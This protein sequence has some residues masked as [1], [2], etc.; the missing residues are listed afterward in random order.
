MKR[1]KASITGAMPASAVALSF[2]ASR[3]YAQGPSGSSGQ[4]GQVKCIGGN[5]CKGMS[6]C[7][8][9]SNAGP[10]RNS[11]KGQ[12]MVYTKTAQ[13][14]TEKGGHPQAGKM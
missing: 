6:A 9:A 7:K 11:C 14:C 4:Q 12:G 2:L 3:S 5:S 1:T 8:T 13:E 10:G